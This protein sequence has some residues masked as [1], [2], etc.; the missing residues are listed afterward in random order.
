MP[1]RCVVVATSNG[2]GGLDKALLQR[3]DVFAFDS[4]KHFAQACQERLEAIWR[5]EAG[6]APLPPDWRT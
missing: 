5:A 6:D 4:G 3:F 1:S 2:A